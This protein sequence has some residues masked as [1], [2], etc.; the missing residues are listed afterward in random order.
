MCLE[1]LKLRRLAGQHLL[2]PADTQTVVKDLCGVQAQFLSHA[3]HGL[4]IR[5]NEVSTD[6]LVKSWTNR[7]T[8]HLFSADDLPLFLHEG[9]T[10]FLRP[11]DTLESDAYISAERKAYFAD[12]I[13]DAVAQG[14]DERES[15]KAVCEKAGMTESESQSLFDPW[16]GT[17][18]ALCETGRLC[19]KVQEKKTYQLC[20]ASE[21][22]AESNARLELARRYFTHFGPATIKDA[23]YFFGTTQT[24]VKEW[25]KQL[26]VAEA[27]VDS[28]SYFYIDSGL[29]SGE[30]PACLFLAGFDQLILGYEKTESLFLPR[31]H[32]R[33]IFN[34]AGIVRPAIL[35]NGTVVGWWNLKNRKLKI[36]LF[37]PADQKLIA[38]T[39]TSLWSDLKQIEYL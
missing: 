36:T 10:Q 25:L 28:K 17:I 18:R 5:C 33:Q 31:E 23:A 24:K 37:S 9:R 35:V 34:L 19:H 1:E 22:M 21:P 3:L 12:L 16:G 14:I 13:V 26:P 30:L 38:D 7:G 27:I 29:P 32:M 11:V 8:M 2:T 20:P 39:A 15:L 4:S 6:G